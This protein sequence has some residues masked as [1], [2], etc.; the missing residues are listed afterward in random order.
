[1]FHDNI[2]HQ[3]QIGLLCKLS[4]EEIEE[5]EWASPCFGVPKKNKTIWLV[6]DF[7]QLNQVLKRKQYPLPT[8]N[9]M[10]Q[11]IRGFV[12]ALVIDLNMGYLLI[13][14]TEST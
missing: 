2:L 8:I 14:L 9:E 12:F 13:P 3:C 6:I 10:F 11:N 4:A 7:H 5:R 1:V